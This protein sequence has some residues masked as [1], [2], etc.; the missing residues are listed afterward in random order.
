MNKINWDNLTRIALAIALIAFTALIIGKTSVTLYKK[1]T[2][3]A[4]KYSRDTSYLITFDEKDTLAVD[5]DTIITLKDNNNNI[6]WT[7]KPCQ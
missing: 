5:I 6:I 7:S 1:A 4:I 2:E 3:P